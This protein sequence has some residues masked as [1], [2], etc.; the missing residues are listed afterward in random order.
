LPQAQVDEIMEKLKVIQ[1]INLGQNDFVSV[2]K[3]MQ[4]ALEKAIANEK[5]ATSDK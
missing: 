3:D 4:D 2:Y 1:D 5:Q